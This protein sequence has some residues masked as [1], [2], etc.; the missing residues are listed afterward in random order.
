MV[1]PWDSAGQLVV[2]GDGKPVECDACPCGDCIYCPDITNSY[3]TILAH[4]EQDVD[5]DG[6]YEVD[7]GTLTLTFGGGGLIACGWGL[8]VSG[9]LKAGDTAFTVLTQP[10]PRG[11][12]VVPQWYVSIQSFPSGVGIG[13]VWESPPTA[14]DSFPKVIVVPFGF[15][16][17]RVTITL[18]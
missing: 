11:P 1:K 14:C 18:P 7:F 10:D 4:V 2:D 17:V 12:D 6:I 15:G 3:D 16:S 13:F 8:F 9:S 5:G